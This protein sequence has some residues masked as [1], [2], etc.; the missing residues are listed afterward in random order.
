MSKQM[1]L[2][3]TLITSVSGAA[4][5]GQT[6]PI[7]TFSDTLS[8]TQGKHAFKGGYELRL[9]SSRGWNGT[10]NPDWYKYSVVSVGAPSGV[11]VTGINS[12]LIPGLTG[13]SVTVMQNLL[14]DLTGSVSNAPLTFNILHPG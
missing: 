3:N 6:S 2:T 14:L 11:P 10:D 7:W 9:T 4:T 13:Q 12:T 8:W 1:I 5:R